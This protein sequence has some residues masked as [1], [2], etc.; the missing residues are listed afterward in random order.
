VLRRPGPP[1]E[2]QT[3]QRERAEF[4]YKLTAKRTSWEC[5]GVA[6]KRWIDEFP[7]ECTLSYANGAFRRSKL[8][9][10]LKKIKKETREKGIFDPSEPWFNAH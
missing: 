2:V 6:V 10:I 3:R 9:E 8:R 4:S 5:H 1:E 7:T